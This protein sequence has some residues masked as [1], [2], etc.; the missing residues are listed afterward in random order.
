MGIKLCSKVVA[1]EGMVS[2]AECR[3][4]HVDDKNLDIRNVPEHLEYLGYRLEKE[5]LILSFKGLKPGRGRLEVELEGR[6]LLIP[7][8][9][10]KTRE[11]F[12]SMVISSNFHY[13]F[14]PENMIRGGNDDSLRHVCGHGFKKTCRTLEPLYH[15]YGL[16]VTWLVDPE[17][18][19]DG[20]GEF[21]HFHHT[22]GD[23][24]GV[25]PTS[26]FHHNSKNFNRDN[27]VDETVAMLKKAIEGVEESFDYYTDIVG[28]DQ[29]VGGVGKNFVKACEILGKKG[30]W[31][32]G[33]D[34][35]T[36]DTSMFHRGCPWDMYK[37][38]RE[39][40]KIPCSYSSDLWGFQ[41]T[42]RD[43]INTVHTPTGAS[44]SVIFS[45]DPDDIRPTNIMQSQRDYY[46]RMLREYRDN[47]K[48]NDYFVFLVHQEDHEAHIEED[49]L[50]LENFIRDVIEDVTPA[51]LQE[52]I[53]WLNIKYAKDEHP[54]QV[55]YLE[56][57]LTCQEEVLWVRGDVVKPDDWASYNGKYPPHGA[58]YNRDYQIILK[59]PD[60][61]PYRV[62]N[63]K[64]AYN[65]METDSYPE[66]R[67]PDIEIIDE[68]L[69][70]Q[71]EAWMY[72]AKLY[73]DE[74]CESYP[75]V[76]WDLPQGLL[77]EIGNSTIIH[78]HKYI[79]L[80]LTLS[81]GQNEISIKLV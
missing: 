73:S 47:M 8:V 49:N 6:T 66:E 9:V 32:L 69:E 50:Y 10:F 43:I 13:G 7:T 18:A 59:K 41:W 20:K 52:I 65:I 28:I 35:F 29:W 14:D 62:Y 64:A 30:I 72:T 79:L 38:D 80:F 16:P 25:M 70:K 46:T 39:N 1:I 21:E 51:T 26:Y 31:G 33:Y 23:D 17:A 78:T 76:I 74:E 27:T 22:F 19:R 48:Y 58:F 68:K 53:M 12:L 2:F 54:S 81:Q 34:H 37:P 71:G 40:I 75:L 60:R 57:P 15:K 42:T 11:F 44:G 45:T 3:V 77:E 4:Q 56:D 61:R 5:R 67:Y 63:Y 24:Y 36:C 55:L